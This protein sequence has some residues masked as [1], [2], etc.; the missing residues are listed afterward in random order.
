VNS[1]MHSQCD[2]KPAYN[3]KSNNQ[4]YTFKINFS[5]EV[6]SKHTLNF[7]SLEGKHNKFVLKSCLIVPI[8]IYFLSDRRNV[9][10]NTNSYAQ[11]DVGI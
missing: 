5:L 3:K 11:M 10:I 2:F 9:K 1:N 7:E 4:F 6:K 8:E